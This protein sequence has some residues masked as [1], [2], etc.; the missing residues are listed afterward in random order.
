[1]KDSFYI[2][3]MVCFCDIPLGGV[4]VHLQRYGDYGIG[5]HKNFCESKN[6][7]PVFYIHSHSAFNFILPKPLV[8][9]ASVIPYVKRYRGEDLKRKDEVRFYNEREWRYVEKDEV[10]M[11]R[12]NRDSVKNICFVLNQKYNKYLRFALNAIEYIIVGRKVELIQMVNFI[13]KSIEA[14]EQEK[15][16]L[17]TKIIYATRIKNDF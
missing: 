12:E 13:E 14:N 5:I 6:I 3:P 17:Y 11:L 10:R 7:N 4:K 16:I 2:A 8:K 15:K 1:M 9:F